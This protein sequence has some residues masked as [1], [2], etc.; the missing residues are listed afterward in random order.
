[1]TPF[2]PHQ[3]VISSHKNSGD[4][5]AVG[6]NDLDSIFRYKL[7]GACAAS[8]RD[9]YLS[10]PWELQLRPGSFY[11]CH[12]HWV[13]HLK[14]STKSNKTVFVNL[15]YVHFNTSWLQL[16]QRQDRCMNPVDIHQI[17]GTSVNLNVNFYILVPYS[18][19]IW[20][21]AVDLL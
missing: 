13:Y 7:K 15:L 4:E 20:Q 18:W 9:F 8:C 21:A 1:M 6:R 12:Q 11:I 5:T 14:Q 2:P 16:T 10:D 19:L 3:P 17:M